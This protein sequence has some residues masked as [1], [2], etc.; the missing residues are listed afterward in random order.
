MLLSLTWRCFIQTD[1]T[2]WMYKLINDIKLW[3]LTKSKWS[4]LLYYVIPT[5]APLLGVD[6]KY[7]NSIIK[8]T[9]KVSKRKLVTSPSIKGSW[10]WP[11]A[12]AAIRKMQAKVVSNVA[13][14]ARKY[15][16]NLR[17]VAMTTNSLR[18]GFHSTSGSS[19]LKIIIMTTTSKGWRTFW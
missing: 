8:I 18:V 12:W 5:F 2:G 1:R 7:I 15:A 19:V 9:P 3:S 13:P 4:L 16:D 6:K 14:I 10:I 17:D 11:R